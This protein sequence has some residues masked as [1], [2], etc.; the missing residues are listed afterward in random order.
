[1]LTTLIDFATTA[2]AIGLVS[3]LAAVGIAVLPW[4]SREATHATQAIDAVARAPF[5]IGAPTPVAAPAR[6]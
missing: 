6:L 4:R 5:Q 2:S 1:M 3:T